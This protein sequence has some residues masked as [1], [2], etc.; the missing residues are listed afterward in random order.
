MIRSVLIIGGVILL[1]ALWMPG[2]QA[3][4]RYNDGCQS[5]HGAFTDATSTKGSIF[6]GDDKHTMHRAANQMNTECDL[7]HTSGDGRD[8]FIGFS[9]G[10][11]TNTGYGCAGCHGRDYGGA[12]GVTG[13]GLRQHHWRAGQAECLSCHADADP[14]AAA[15]LA[16]STSPPYYG[17]ADTNASDPCNAVAAAKT[18]ENWTIGDFIG[19]DNNGDGIYDGSDVACAPDDDPAEVRGLRITTHDPVTQ[20]IGVSY[21]LGCETSET[22]IEYG[23]LSAVPTLGY[24]G[25]ECGLGNFGTYAW[26]YAGTPDS[27]FFVL[28]GNNGIAEGSY[29]V[30]QS[31]ERTAAGSDSQ[32]C[33]NLLQQLNSLCQ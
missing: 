9:D 28:V 7:C 2:P 19:T 25:Q 4:E 20:T 12:D 24:S 17:S 33:S 23:P 16:E 6:P 31:G 1:L 11:A 5:C 21:V 29:G 27:M 32:T 15:T 26:D 14:V 3:Y 10:T 13:R 18:G 22:T 30:G 8:P